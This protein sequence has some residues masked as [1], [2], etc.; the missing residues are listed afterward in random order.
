MKR[1][2]ETSLALLAVVASG[3]QS[4][5]PTELIVDATPPEIP[6]SRVPPLAGG[7]LLVTSDGGRAVVSDPERDR[8]LVV[9]L[10]NGE[11]AE[12]ALESGDEPGRVVQGGIDRAFVALRGAGAVVAIDVTGAAIAARSSVCDAPRGMSYDAAGNSPRLYVACASGELVT[13]DAASLGEL[14]RLYLGPDLRDVIT[15]GDDLFVTRF[16]SAELMRISAEGLTEQ[17]VRPAPHSVGVDEID[18]VPTVAWRA[19]PMGDGR[20]AMV[21]Q[22]ARVTEVELNPAPAEDGAAG[23][24]ATSSEAYGGECE[25]QLVLAELT[26]FEGDDLYPRPVGAATLGSMHLPVDFAVSADGQRAAVIDPASHQAKEID[27]L[28][29]LGADCLGVDV[30]TSLGSLEGPPVAVAYAGIDVV[31]QTREPAALHVFHNQYL[32]RTIYLGGESRADTGFDLFHNTSEMPNSFGLACASCHPE[33]RDDG[34]VWSFSGEGLRRTQSLAGTLAGTAP[35]HWGGNLPTLGS[36]MDEVSTR[37]M[38]GVKQSPERVAALE[39]WLAT[40]EPL[41]PALDPVVEPSQ[42]EQGQALFESETVGCASCHSGPSLTNNRNE[43]VGFGESLQ[44]PS[45]IGIGM[46]AP[47]MHDGCAAT[48]MDRFEPACGGDQHG[49]LTGLDEADLQALVAYMNTL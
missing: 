33:G 26:L 9:G 21:H 25:Q 43:S 46:R 4:G 16:R 31:V 41:R 12:I 36:L 40:L 23:D 2:Y 19:L 42:V 24:S 6:S 18:R 15:R 39:S 7:T 20:I 38:G 49:D 17:L 5:L 8:V 48:L 10:S 37:R 47:F 30:G 32:D 13:L 44:V 22:T 29:E 11:V 45:L 28:R 14:E 27:L 1:R 35:F 3:C 34:H